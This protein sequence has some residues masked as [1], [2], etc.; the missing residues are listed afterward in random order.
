M[1]RIRLAELNPPQREAVTTTEGPLLVLAGAGSGKTRV[2]TYRIAH[3]LEKG[4]RPEAI[5]AVSFTNKAA[6][7]MRERVERLCPPQQARLLTLSTFHSLGLLILKAEQAALGMSGG[8]T[9]YDTA[10]QLGV[11]REI[12]REA[13]VADRRL[14]VKGI[15]SR[16]SRCKNAGLTPA[17]FID[18]IKKARSVNE[19]DGYTAEVFPRYAERMRALHAFDFD[20]LLVETLRLLRENDVVRKRWQ[21]RFRYMM[22]D[23]Y[24]DTNRC[25]LDLLRLLCETHGNLAVVGD[26]DQSIYGWRGAETKNILEFAQQFP[27][28]KVIKLEENYRSTGTILRAANAVIA[29]NAQRHTKTLWTSRGDGDPL[30]VVIAPDETT[31]ATFVAEEIDRLLA[32]RRYQLRDMAVLYRATK[33]GEAIEEA[34]RQARIEYRVIGG[35]AFFERKE[36]KDAIAYLKVICYPHDELALRRVVNYPPRGLG[37]AAM[38]RLT[39]AHK[40]AVKSR[41]DS[42]LWDAMS[43]IVRSGA[44]KAQASIVQGGLFSPPLQRAPSM[45]L[46]D[47]PELPELPELGEVLSDRARAALTAFVDGV[48]R[49]RSHIMNAGPGELQVVAER[50][51]RDMGVHDDLTRSGPTALQAERRHR[52]LGDFLASMQRY[53]DKAGSGFDLLSYLNRLTLNSQDDDADDSLRDAVTLSTLHGAKGLEFGVVFFIGVE[54][55]LLPHRRT[56]YPREADFTLA[57]GA[58][59][60]TSD[61]AHP[62]D[63]GEERRLCYVGITRARERLYISWTRMRNGRPDLRYPSRFLEDLPKDT[64][65]ERDLEGPAV[66]QDPNEEARMVREMI[67]RAKAVSA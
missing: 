65:R 48:Q 16:I 12:L 2:I 32:T 41:R 46:S 50:F 8:F 26:D 40:Q 34:F 29:K 61:G 6:E 52:S 43:A 28:A 38:E 56:L 59:G 42:S 15:L 54:E 5:L 47:D 31:E 63:L 58:E 49:Y 45:A 19:Y 25:Q 53:A 20:D 55:E 11:V 13:R 10:D 35:T 7:E 67:E 9:I 1:T 27:G 4:V 62:A 21:A 37:P 57:A 64:Y 22:I 14:D 39:T 60:D 44:V 24:Q 33:Q 18:Q 17:T 3:L 36:V 51:L 30:E 23:E 66:K